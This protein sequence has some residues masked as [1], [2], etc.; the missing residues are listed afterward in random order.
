MFP[1]IIKYGEIL[2]ELV[3]IASNLLSKFLFSTSKGLIWN[4]EWGSALTAQEF[5]IAAA[6]QLQDGRD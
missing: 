4:S 1:S 2:N 3:S 6:A 5:K